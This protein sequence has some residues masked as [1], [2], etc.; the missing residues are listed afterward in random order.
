MANQ[1]LAKNYTAGGAVSPYR[2]VKPGAS[3]GT[4]VQAAAATDAL[5]G[6]CGEIGPASGERVDIIKSGIGR[7]E[8]GGNVTR[9]DPLTSDSS[10]KA[11]L[12]A[13]SAGSNVRIIGYAEVS[14]VS[15]DIGDILIAPGLMQG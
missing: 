7:A 10:G 6:I 8:F 5:M 15:G 12:A 4:V 1:L 2:I 9:G 3:N 11:I 13:P 14:G